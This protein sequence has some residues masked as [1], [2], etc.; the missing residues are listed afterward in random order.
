[1]P[2]KV[3]F[4]KGLPM[5][6]PLLPKRHDIEEGIETYANVSRLRKLPN[7]NTSNIFRAVSNPWKGKG[8]VL[9]CN[10]YVDVSLWHE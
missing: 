9:D 4:L 1:M 2:P 6:S 10:E 7:R 8:R 3:V 5:A